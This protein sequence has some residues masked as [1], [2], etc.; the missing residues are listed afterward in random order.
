M[1]ELLGML[2]YVGIVLAITFLIITFVG[3]RTM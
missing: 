3:Q 1:R 2:V